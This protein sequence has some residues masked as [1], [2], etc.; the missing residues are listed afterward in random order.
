MTSSRPRA[1]RRGAPCRLDCTGRRDAAG[2][3]RARR[4]PQPHRQVSL[5]EG[6]FG[7]SRQSGEFHSSICRPGSSPRRLTDGSLVHLDGVRGNGATVT[8][9]RSEQKRLT[10]AQ[11]IDVSVDVGPLDDVQPARPEERGPR[12]LEASD[13]RRRAHNRRRRET[14]PTEASTP[15]PLTQRV[16]ASPGTPLLGP[17]SRR[18]R[19]PP[20]RLRRH[21]AVRYAA[22]LRRCAAAPPRRRAASLLRLRVSLRR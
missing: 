9:A 2:C 15:V 5:T 14:Q 3:R 12:G 22:P 20:P 4:R 17:A 11:P 18:V 10:P 16:R 21:A 8:G 6:R 1:P 13:S 7:A 19:P